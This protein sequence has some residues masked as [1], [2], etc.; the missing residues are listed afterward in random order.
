ML[1]QRFADYHVEGPAVQQRPQDER[2]PGDQ[3]EK[4]DPPAKAIAA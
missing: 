1:K 4:A 3:D 2:H